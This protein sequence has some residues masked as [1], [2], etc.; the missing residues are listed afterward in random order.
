MSGFVYDTCR[1]VFDML[2]QVLTNTLLTLLYFFDSPTA[3][4]LS[5]SMFLHYYATP[6]INISSPADQQIQ[7]WGCCFC[8]WNKSIEA[9][10]YFRQTEITVYCNAQ[11][12]EELGGPQRGYMATTINEEGSYYGWGRKDAD[13]TYHSVKA[14]TYVHQ[15]FTSTYCLDLLCR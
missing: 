9:S 4:T 10:E 6:L 12:K 8:F 13:K 3:I 15:Y 14:Y 2:C 11:C 7:V 1:G 5:D